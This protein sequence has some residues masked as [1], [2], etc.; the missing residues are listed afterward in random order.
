VKRKVRHT[1]T[2]IAFLSIGVFLFY[3]ASLDITRGSLAIEAASAH[4]EVGRGLSTCDGE[5]KRV[6][7]ASVSPT[8]VSQPFTVTDAE[9]HPILQ[10]T[11]TAEPAELCLTPGAYTFQFEGYHEGDVVVLEGID[12]STILA[13][14]MK[15]ASIPGILFSALL[16]YLAIVSR[17]AR[18]QL[19]LDPMGHS[20]NR[21]RLIH[22]VS[23]AYFA[24]LF[25]PRSGELARCV[26]INQTDKV[27]VDRLLGTVIS[28]RVVD[29]LLLLSITTLAVITNLDAFSRLLA[30]RN[31]QPSAGAATGNP[32]LFALVGVA[33][34][35]GI[36][37]MVFRRSTFVNTAYN[38]VKALLS[39]VGEGLRS[40]LT[41]K[42][43]RQFI[44]HTFFIWLMYFLSTW[45]IFKSIDAT[46]AMPLNHALFI[47]VAG[48]FG[49]VIPAP[50]G[51]GSYHWMVKLGFIAI[52][53]SGTLGFAV[54]NVLWL[55]Q[56]VMMIV[57]GGLGY[58]ALMW[59]RVR[60]NRRT[61][62]NDE[63]R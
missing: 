15:R 28:E 1:V 43:K 31:P 38:K 39:G 24:N 57:V 18:W 40:V 46:A 2:Y 41:M 27:P 36:L 23:F 58:L 42:K 50:G 60:N 54:A 16:G 11:L 63:Q 56:N 19:M 48:G 6:R 8:L 10:G 20:V 47:M 17:G 59:F 13:E 22:A 4:F 5:A 51:I 34:A 45:V 25:V 37:I 32:M 21:W 7:I 44:F 14:D 53:L 3:L 9:S 26:A 61:F 29:M 30:G 52:G 49:M 62:E 55:T 33:I 12:K 35:I